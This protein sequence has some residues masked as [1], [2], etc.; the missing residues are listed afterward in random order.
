MKSP[1]LLAVVLL[2]STLGAVGYQVFELNRLR[3]ENVNAVVAPLPSQPEGELTGD[4]KVPSLIAFASLNL[5]GIANKPVEKPVVENLVPISALKLILIGTIVKSKTEENS[6]LIQRSNRETKRYFIGDVI[7][8]GVSL[9]SVA[10][11][12]VIL[13]RDDASE[14]LRYPQGSFSAAFAPADVPSASPVAA[15]FPQNAA[16]AQQ[17]LQNNSAAT[18]SPNVPVPT[19]SRRM[20]RLR[21]RLKMP[22]PPPAANSAP[23]AAEPSTSPPADEQDAD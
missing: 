11:D 19:G 3:L 12:Q 9:A 15:P 23:P 4:K 8:G 21:D 22:T 14:V 10:V 1:V 18:A 16:A 2:L 7:E 6:A 5:M 13:K 20:L 17:A